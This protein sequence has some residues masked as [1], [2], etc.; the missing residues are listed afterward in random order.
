VDKVLGF[1]ILGLGIGATRARMVP[2]TKN[3]KLVCVCDLQEDKARKIAEELEC[4]WCTEY[5]KMLYRKDIDVIGVFTPSGTHADYAMMAVDAG[6]HVFTTKPMDISTEK[7][8]KLIAA[9]E[10]AGVIL[11]V[12]FDLRYVDDLRRIKLAIDNGR[13]GKIILSDVRLK[14]YRDQAYYDGGYP[15]GWRSRSETEKG[16]AANQGVHYIDLLLW[17]IGPIE[18]VYGKSGTFTHKIETEDT[19]VALL[20]FKN[21]S[22]GTFVTT[23]TSIPDLGTTIEINGGGGAIVLK[24]KEKGLVDLYYCKDNP[25]ASLEEFTLPEDR[26]MNI[27]EDM[28]SAITKGTPVA[29]NGITGRESTKV[30]NAIYESSKTGKTINL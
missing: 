7:C 28:V 22:W 23:T 14:W 9:A 21:G 3:A 18:S 15:P 1:G 30:F 29:V 20:S 10:K 24:T 26:P 13:I 25:N 6:K 17:Q 27:I 2:R 11:A 5:E 4:D 16:S 8:D 19:T 12:D